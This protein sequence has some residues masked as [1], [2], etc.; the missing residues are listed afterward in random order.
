MLFLTMF[1]SNSYAETYRIVTESAEAKHKSW[2]GYWWSMKNAESVL[3]WQGLYG[4]KT[5]SPYQ[6][7]EFTRC[8]TSHSQICKNL[9]ENYSKNNAI[10]LS[11]LMKFDLFMKRYVE[12]NYGQHADV[13][14]Y[15]SAASYE[16]DIH[17]IGNNTNHR[18]YEF[19][20]FAGKCIGWAL[21]TFDYNEPTKVKNILGIDFTPADIKAILATQYNGAQFFTDG[22][23]VG[24]EYRGPKKTPAHKDNPQY[25][26]KESDAYK[27]VTPLQFVKALKNTIGHGTY[28]EADLD[29]DIGV[30]NYP[31]HKY[32]IKFQKESDSLAKAEIS[33]E[34]ANDEVKIDDVFTTSNIRRD[35]KQRTFYAK[36]NLPESWS[37]KLEDA[38]SSY[39]IGESVHN[40]PDALILGMEDNWKETILDYIDADT[41]IGIDVNTELFKS[42]DG[43]DL[44]VDELLYEYYLD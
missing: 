1:L 12:K 6:V 9:I 3:G 41:G 19:S 22:L 44:V 43:W 24:L 32:E 4:R 26:N 8:L 18:L 31:I 37:G 27:D 29:P 17:Y 35:M 25:G 16:L 20:G 36:F 21:S 14:M 40:H 38:V 30:W 15:S 23:T 42:H 2:G 34:F 33:I 5:F 39:W 13:S 28:L 10:S 7:S 11:P